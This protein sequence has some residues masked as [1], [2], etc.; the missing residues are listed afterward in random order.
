MRLMRPD[1]SHMR[2]TDNAGVPCVTGEMAG[3]NITMD[4]AAVTSNQSSCDV[5]VYQSAAVVLFPIFYSVVFIISA[6]G[7]S[8]VLYVICQRKQKSNS[9]SIY[10]VNLALS[11][12]LFTLALP[13]RITYYIR[14]FDWPFG[15]FLCKITTLLFFT[16][17]YAGI[18]FM[19]CISL[20]RYLAMVHPHRLQCLR[21]VK[22][23]R[24]VCCLVWALVSLQVAPLLLR[25]MLHEHQGRRTCM[26]YFNFE[27]SRFT[28]YLLLLA[29]AMSFCC[30][31]T[32]IM[33][34]YAKINLKLRDA[35]KKNSVTGR[36]RRNHRAN[37]IIL[38]ILLTFIVCFSPYHINVIQFMSR[39][40][41]HQP[42]CEELRAFKVALQ[43]TVS[44]MNFNCC[45]DPV[46]YF[47]AIKTYKKRVM[48]LF[49]DYL[50]TSGA[51]SKMTAENSSS[52]T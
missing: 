10:L 31:L 52:N 5:F 7:N 34:C 29:C 49:K 47:F 37:T 1:T 30:P 42:T 24:R 40:I 27:G 28:P 15:D 16:N 19:T 46:I 44:L 51:S 43:V 36:S 38:L 32:T 6:C 4:P 3:E 48:S 9:T 2:P 35:A 25:S 39:K 50:Y 12:T 17:T 41:H 11:D 20:D 8:L 13:G 45:L 26:E 18:A 22:V 33:C 21:S 23:V 14:H